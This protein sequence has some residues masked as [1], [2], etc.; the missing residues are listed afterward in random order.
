MNISKNS[1]FLEFITNSS[2]ET[3]KV[4]YDF[5]K[6]INKNDILALHG[7]LGA[8]KTCFVQGLAEAMG[9]A[10]P[11][12]SP[13]F[14]IINRYEGTP[15]LFHADL[16]RISSVEEI[17]YTALEEC[18]E[19]DGITAIEW[20]EKAEKIL[21]ERTIHIYFQPLSK[22]NKRLIKIKITPH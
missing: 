4:A 5:L 20:A 12:T 2:E 6:K 11:I 19:A 8:G 1:L 3:K 15:P 16:Y 22:E 13:T 10:K 17:L 18:F 7:E 14:I 21:P 9:I